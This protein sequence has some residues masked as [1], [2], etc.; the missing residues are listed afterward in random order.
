MTNDWKYD[1]YRGPIPYFVDIYVKLH[2]VNSIELSGNNIQ[3]HNYDDRKL[4][5]K[6]VYKFYQY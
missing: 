1:W 5:L 6:W 2:A 3:G 4:V